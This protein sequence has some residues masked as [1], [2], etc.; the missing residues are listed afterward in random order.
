MADDGYVSWY[1]SK[2]WR[3]LP[4]LYRTLD[5]G[6]TPD[7]AGP[8]QELVNRIGAETAVVRRSIDRLWEN[9][10]IETCDDWVVPYIGDL[11]ATRLV[12]CLDARAQRVDVAK[13]IYYR[14]RAGTLGLLEELAADIAGRDARCV[15][16]FRRLA[17]TRHQF[18]PAIG[19]IPTFTPG[20]APGSAVIQGLAGACSGT[21]AGGFADLRNAYAAANSAGAFDEYAHTADFRRG[22]HSIG[23][24]NISHL[25]VFIWWLQSFPAQAVTPVGNGATP[26]CFT[27]D[28]TGRRIPLFAPSSRGKDSFGEA[29]VSPDE[30]N[31]PVPVRETLW[32]SFP[33]ELYD[34]AYSVGLGAGGTYA[35][36]PRTDVR[37]HPEQ[38]LFSFVAAPPAGTILTNYH[39][40]FSSVIGA[41]GFDE[42]FV[43]KL[44]EPAPLVS[45]AGG[46]GLD[47]ALASITGSGTVEIGDSMTYPGPTA[48]L[49]LPTAATVELRALNLER[50]V[51][52]WPGAGPNAWTITGDG[53]EL[54]LQGLWLQGADL[55]LA[56]HFDTVRLRL[57]TVDPGTAAAVGGGPSL[58]DTAMDGVPLGPSTIWIEGEIREL[59]LERCITGPIRTRNGGDLE[60]LTASDSIIQSIAT[61]A[62]VAAAPIFDPAD[63]AMTWKLSSDPVTKGIV[64][65]LPKTTTDMLAAYT[66]GQAPSATLQAALKT[67]LNS[68]DRAAME[69]AYPLA[70]AD[71]A[72][73]FSSG[74]ARLSRCTVLGPSSLH[75][76]SASECILDE[77][78]TVEDTQHGCVRFCAYA[79]G[80][81][82]H[83]PYRSVTV[84][85]RGPLFRSRRFG[86]P[87]YARLYRLAD[88]AILNPGPGDTILGGAQN[89]SEMGAFCLEAVT[90]RK[91][92]LAIKFEE[93]A[94][95]GVFPVW[96]DAD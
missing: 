15:E 40:G 52:R 75:R 34:V 14:R 84:P 11:L 74:E 27:F 46:T 41:G 4:E 91:R 83:Q 65:G 24:H 78:T 13:T 82:L 87:D 1:Q 49:A 80:S 7:G 12:S 47:G 26:P 28:P 53:G 76:L 19:S 45:I 29:W 36:V 56:G 42:R 35:A 31:L 23:W 43:S 93:Y 94:P 67:A 60:I 10:S 72:L 81:N 92:G 64:A 51:L 61:H 73:G 86:D 95:L 57:V 58:F 2:L 70:L 54:I 5:K 39:F 89:G 3:L 33:D 59:T 32:A 62:L 96:I 37:I 90:L 6:E 17:R 66:P 25:G 30:W 18:D 38:G 9:Q 50:P 44:D 79:T 21:P 88:A 20:S 16:F 85:P 22:A 48:A 63:L 77:L 8:L 68:Q 69:K 55:V 71:L